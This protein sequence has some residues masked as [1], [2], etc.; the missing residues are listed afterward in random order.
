LEQDY[1]ENTKS[2]SAEDIGHF[3]QEDEVHIGFVT[4][5]GAAR[6]DPILQGLTFKN[7]ECSLVDKC[8]TTHSI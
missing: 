3:D 5:G 1:H 2:R 7:A 6:Q 8:D 4:R